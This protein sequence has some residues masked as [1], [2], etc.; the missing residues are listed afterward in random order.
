MMVVNVEEVVVETDYRGL[1]VEVR[2]AGAPRETVTRLLNPLDRIALCVICNRAIPVTP[3]SPAQACARPLR[4]ATYCLL[5]QL[6][7]A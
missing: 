6:G 3:S 7:I 5:S 2:M 4:R 1:L